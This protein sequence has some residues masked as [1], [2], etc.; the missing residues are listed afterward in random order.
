MLSNSDRVHQ[1]DK[2]F[3]ADVSDGQFANHLFVR[4]RAKG[5]RFT[6]VDFNHTIFDTCYL[7]DCVF[8]SCD[9][10]GCRFIGTN[11]HG[12]KFSGCKFD[13]STFERTIIESEILDTEC[14]GSENLK[15]RFARTLRMNYQQLGDA[16]AVNRS[17][18]VELQATGMHLHKAWHSNESYYRKKYAGWRRV[19]TFVEWFGFKVLDFIW[20]NGESALKLLR[21]TV[22]VLLVMPLIDTHSVE[23]YIDGLSHAPQ[24]FLGTI[25]PN[26]YPSWYLT[27]ILTLRLIAFGFFMSII[28]KRLNRR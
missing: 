22:L 10:V 17:I 25:S 28:I 26:R 23:S 27:V 7:R 12:S 9:F 13:Y 18:G 20:G 15:M 14:P 4:L 2:E 5:R 6:K 3:D 8:D 19:T 24:V 11:L 16:K 1:V 21:A